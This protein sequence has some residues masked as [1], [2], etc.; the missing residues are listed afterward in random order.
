MQ[1]TG[2][3]LARNMLHV[4]LPQR[5]FVQIKDSAVVLGQNKNFNE[6][7]S[8]CHFASHLVTNYYVLQGQ[9]AK[10]LPPC[11]ISEKWPLRKASLSY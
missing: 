5:A 6:F 9:A 2:N 1:C 3:F 4:E 8:L 7:L 11:E 10:L